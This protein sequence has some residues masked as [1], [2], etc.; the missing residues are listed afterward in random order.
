[1]GDGKMAKKS[2]KE[3]HEPKK[4]RTTPKKTS[5]TP[6]K[7]RVRK[8]PSGD[9][10]LPPLKKEQAQ[11]YA[12]FSEACKK[13][14]E[15]FF[16]HKINT[17]V[18]QLESSQALVAVIRFMVMMHDLLEVYGVMQFNKHVS[19]TLYKH[20]DDVQEKTGQKLP[21]ARVLLDGVKTTKM[22]LLSGVTVHPLPE[23]EEPKYKIVIPKNRS[24]RS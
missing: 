20:L 13:V 6:K 22:E 11:A 8:A 23:F 12:Q 24:K 9:K 16:K 7:T 17:R 21:L 3:K 18:A 19:P 10:S 4:T 5:T 15:K 1:M 14:Y 2:D